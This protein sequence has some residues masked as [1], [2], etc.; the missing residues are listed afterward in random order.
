MRSSPQQ[1]SSSFN[2]TITLIS[3]V[4]I[5]PATFAAQNDE[6]QFIEEIVV[7]A[8][9]REERILDVPVTMTAF[10]EKLI[11]ELGMTGDE[12]LEQLVPGLQFAYD[13]EGNGISMRGIGT[14]KGVQS[15]AD[16][17]VAFY[18][19][20][21][22]S[23]KAY[24][25]A[26]NMF[27][28]DRIEVA[29]GPQGTMNGR[30][31]IAGSISVVS[32]KPTDEWD[33][34]LE[35]EFTDQVTQRYGIAGGG[36][37]NDNFSF[38]ITASYYEGDGAQ[39][40]TGSGGDYHAP[41]QQTFAP[42]LRFR[43]DRL[44]MNL[45]YMATRDEGTSR[46]R[47]PFTEE[48]RTKPGDGFVW[49]GIEFDNPNPWYLYDKPIPS[50]SNC[51][52]GQF[53]E[54]GDICEDLENKVLSN[55]PSLQDNETDRWSFNADFELT[56]TL[57]LRYT[58]GENES[59]TFG[60]ED[61]DGT[62]RVGSADDPFIPSDLDAAERLLWIENEGEFSDS[63]NAWLE[64]DEESSHE[65]QL[66]SNFDGPFNFVAG[67]Y[68]YE[69]TSSWRDRQ[70][71]WANPLNFTDAE[72]AV[73]EVDVDEDGEPD[74]TSC[75]DF[76]ENFVLPTV[77]ED[78]ELSRDEALFRV[79]GCAVGADHS[80]QTG[81]GAGASAETNAV[82]V[83]G[84]Y[85]M[86]EQWKVSG[87][88]RWTEDKKELLNSI[89]GDHGVTGE[90]FD[91]PIL[92]QDVLPVRSGSWDK[93]IGHIALEW[94]PEANRLYY[95]RIST[96][97][98]AGGFNQISGVTSAE[99]IASVIP[100]SFPGEDLINYEVGVKGLFLEN[101]LML[102][103][104][105]Y[106]QDFSGYH[107]NATQL[108]AEGQRG[109]QEN[110]F[111][112][113]TA[114]I[115][116]TEIWGFEVEGTYYITENWRLSGFYNYLDSSVGEHSAQFEDDRTEPDTFMHTYVDSECRGEGGTVEECTE[117][118]EL[119][120]PRDVTG[121]RLPQ[122]PKHKAAL[123]VQYTRPLQNLGTASVLSTWSYTGERWND[124]GNVPYR[125]L[126]AYDRFDLRATWDSP[127]NV[128][129]VTAYV[130]NVFDDIGIQEY[131]FGVGWLTE[132]RQVGVQFRWRPEL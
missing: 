44:D 119:D 33:M 81:G 57:S 77:M 116:D 109:T 27:D 122:Q 35:A 74:F 87:G 123:T 86:N 88:L 98:R 75:N 62:D 16:Q 83:S 56:E 20:G 97:F 17:A 41:D 127:A 70:H 67:I 92:F 32:R 28:L 79:P 128:W 129:S 72:V 103:A 82:F 43:N 102:T 64:D 53:S 107:L 25:I 126:D 118:V 63:T 130:Q 115:D 78:E 61:S 36:P 8:Q 65:L 46:A 94:S 117:T 73:L 34:N 69:N 90:F 59:H 14:Q 18:V 45:R 3:W 23:Y 52:P 54:F 120:L 131:A 22:Y 39:E 113:F 15:Q 55:R 101:R 132:H 66:F 2:L 76:F 114:G 60:S 19:D 12:D 40:N 11:R 112:E 10:S 100:V 71:D 9:K 84:D 85:Q 80:F 50:V 99:I 68:T 30:N 104:G 49:M 96:G 37:I 121:N 4:L 29:R 110:P 38:R 91:V 42:Q 7:T 93:V 13:S 95:A 124:I 106:F 21:V 108:I 6:T 31:S 51:P 26:P 1:N 48:D 5:A 125:K 89:N 58:Y 111:R 47:V 105:A 24:N